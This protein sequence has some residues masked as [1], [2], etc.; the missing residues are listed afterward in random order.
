MCGISVLVALGQNAT[1]KQHRA[2]DLANGLKTPALTNR[3]G[4]S[5][6][7]KG[8]NG[9]VSTSDSASNVLSNR[10]VKASYN[11]IISDKLDQSL[12]NIAHR[13]P[14]SPGKW[15]T[16]DSRVGTFQSYATPTKTYTHYQHHSS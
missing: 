7:N 16:E 13:S 10:A 6:S 11:D 2:P 4:V 3:T 1:V 12:D 15:I 8:T 9:T 5:A 14:D